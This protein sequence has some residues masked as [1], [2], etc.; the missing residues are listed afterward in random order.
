MFA[1]ALFGLAV[2]ISQPAKAKPRNDPAQWVRASD[3]PRIDKNAA[4]TT[5]DLTVDETGKV[6]RC[7]IIVESGSASLDQAICNA[8]MKRARFRPAME[9]EEQPAFSIYRDRVVWLPNAYG[10]N[11]AFDGADI[12]ISSPSVVGKIDTLGEFVVLMNAEGEAV[13]C[14]VVASSGEAALDELACSALL[15]AEVSAPIL[16]ASDARVKGLRSFFVA[17]QPAEKITAEIR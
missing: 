1:S 7:V 5:F 16:D 12:V 9:A 3:L 6:I 4:V 14:N 11:S 8:V 15:T 10:N 17:F 2:A 13:N